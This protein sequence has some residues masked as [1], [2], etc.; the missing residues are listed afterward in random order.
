MRVSAV[1][2]ASIAAYS[3][4]CCSL[5]NRPET[6]VAACS[7]QA[8]RVQNQPNEHAGF[9]RVKQRTEIVNYSSAY[10]L[11][12]TPVLDLQ[13]LL[14]ARKTRGPRLRGCPRPRFSATLTSSFNGVLRDA[15]VVAQQR[16]IGFM[17]GRIQVPAGSDTMGSSE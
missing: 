15:P 9:R 13:P 17:V 6:R 4:T 11:S 1:C 2:S 3:N 7:T 16:R 14:C 10:G 12:P 8:L 5:P